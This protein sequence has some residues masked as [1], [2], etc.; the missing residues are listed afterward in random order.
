[1][2]KHA[3]RVASESVFHRA[4]IGAVIA[5]GSRILSSGYNRIGY[6][7]YLPNRPYPESIH[8]EEAAILKLLRE[9]RLRDL[10]GSTIF[11]SRINRSG[12]CRLSK[13][14]RNCQDLIRSV[15]IKR[16]VYTTD[17]GVEEYGL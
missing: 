7:K 5:K 6:S 2:I 13:P 3:S 12:A 8:A 15:G 14:C 1:M 16:V 11:V 9:R 10:A 4:R 17:T